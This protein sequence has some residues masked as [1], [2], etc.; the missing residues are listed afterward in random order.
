[1]NSMKVLTAAM[2]AM[3]GEALDFN[4]YV[5]KGHAL[6]YDGTRAMFEA[7]RVNTPLTTGLIQW[8]LNS[9]WPSIY[10]Q[11]YDYYGAPVAA[12]YGTKKAC[13]PLQ[14]IYNY[15]DSRVYLVNEGNTSGDVIAS[16]KVFD[17]ASALLYEAETRLFTSYRN[18][19]A[20]FDLSA[21]DG[22]PHFVA[23]ELETAENEIIT[24]NFYCIAA[25]RNEYNWRRNKWYYT[26][27]SEYSDLSF[28]FG[29]QPADVSMET[30]WA[31]G[32]Y[33]VILTNKGRSISYMNIL[34]ALDEN[35]ELVVPAYW[36]DNFFALLPGQTKTVNCRT[37]KKNVNIILNN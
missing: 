23:L 37:E 30:S 3:Y 17:D 5:R 11:L 26:P 16:V 28:A 27:I 12:Y 31:D 15:K 25:K 6:D 7:F 34:K 8:M 21:F 35:G 20:A 10:W 9:A 1:M 19:V 22:R 2:N 33:S 4:D 13:E 32:V 18:T 14:L 29:Q 24:D 36:S